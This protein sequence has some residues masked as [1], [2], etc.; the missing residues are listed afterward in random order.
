MLLVLT[1]RLEKM[2]ELHKNI[3]TEKKERK[4]QIDD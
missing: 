2:V 4:N 1:R 3:A